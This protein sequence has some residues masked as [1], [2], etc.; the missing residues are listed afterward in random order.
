MS[1]ESN[2]KQNSDTKRTSRHNIKRTSRHLIDRFLLVTMLHRFYLKR[3]LFLGEQKDL[4]RLAEEWTDEEKDRWDT[5]HILTAPLLTRAMNIWLYHDDA[6]QL[7]LD[8]DACRSELAKLMM[9][10]YTGKQKLAELQSMRQNSPKAEVGIQRKTLANLLNEL[11]CFEDR[12]SSMQNSQS[13]DELAGYV[14]GFRLQRCF[15]EESGV[16]GNLFY[17]N[18]VE[19][20]AHEMAAVQATYYPFLDQ[21]TSSAILD[22]LLLSDFQRETFDE[23]L[24]YKVSLAP[25]Q[26]LPAILKEAL[27]ATKEMRN[28]AMIADPAENSFACFWYELRYHSWQWVNGKLELVPRDQA[29]PILPWHVVYSNGY[30]YLVG[31]RLDLP[32]AITGSKTPEKGLVLSNLRLDRITEL[33]RVNA[34]DGLLEDFSFRELCSLC[35][36]LEDW[37]SGS[38]IEYRNAS[39]IMYSGNTESLYIDCHESL[40]N[41]AVDDFGQVN[42]KLVTTELPEKDWVRIQIEHAVWTGVRLWLLQHA[43]YS[44]LARIP[45]QM[46]KYQEIKKAL[47]DAANQYQL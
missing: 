21:K 33:V 24:E 30:F 45:K 26:N 29:I 10:Q 13:A 22:R 19:Q 14:Q 47:E 38:M 1:M 8:S 11:V 27:L 7:C 4:K 6:E 31:L 32:P 37:F 25:Q 3:L 17:I 40:M 34:T 36:A 35:K 28:Y 44:R 20:P 2:T 39:T 23:I 16:K 18:P 46:Q 12:L 42:L 5:R 41:S 9:L 15:P 43:G